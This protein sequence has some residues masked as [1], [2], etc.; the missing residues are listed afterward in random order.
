MDA[1]R[2]DHKARVLRSRSTLSQKE[3]RLIPF[4]TLYTLTSN[5]M[6]RCRVSLV[7]RGLD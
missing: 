5:C 4:E 7:G 1:F 6:C 3:G 2:E